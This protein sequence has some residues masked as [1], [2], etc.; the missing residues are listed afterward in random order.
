DD[1]PAIEFSAPRAYYHQDGLGAAA[2]AWIAARLDPAAAPIVGAPP[3]PFALR[4]NLL[5]AQLALRAGGRPDE[6]RAYL[7]ALARAPGARPDGA[8]RGRGAGGRGARGRPAPA[9]AGGGGGGGAGGG[10]APGGPPPAPPSA[11]RR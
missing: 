11:D 2:L 5:R 4:A 3:A 6:L 7:D 9:T 8:G 10:A 1:R